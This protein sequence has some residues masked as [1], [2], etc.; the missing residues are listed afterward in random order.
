M[1]VRMRSYWWIAFFLRCQT[2]WK[3]L[4]TRRSLDVEIRV[5]K[6]RAT[7]QSLVEPIMDMLSHSCAMRICI[8]T[9]HLQL[10]YHHGAAIRLGKDSAKCVVVEHGLMRG[11]CERDVVNKFVYK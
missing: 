5:W 3:I 6:L 7:K 11:V 9:P 1:I 4:M 10:N 2:L 8:E